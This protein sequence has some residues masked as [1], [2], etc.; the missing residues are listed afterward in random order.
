MSLF[1]AISIAPLYIIIVQLQIVKELQLYLNKPLFLLQWFRKFKCKTWKSMSTL[2]PRTQEKRTAENLKRYCFL[3]WTVLVTHYISPWIWCTSNGQFLM[4][5]YF[6]IL[7]IPGN[8]G[9]GCYFRGSGCQRPLR[10]PLS[11]GWTGC[12]PKWNQQKNCPCSK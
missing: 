11:T 9:S 3:Y 6:M 2:R 8:R 5:V 1:C 4:T 10:L 7:F 12:C